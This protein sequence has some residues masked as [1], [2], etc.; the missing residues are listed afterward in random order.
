MTEWL[1]QFE[2]IARL[3]WAPWTL[4][5]AAMNVRIRFAIFA[6]VI[7][8]WLVAALM[9]G[10]LYHSV[11]RPF[12]DPSRWLRDLPVS[13]LCGA[14]IIALFAIL[15][16]LAWADPDMTTVAQRARLRAPLLA[17]FCVIV[18][19]GAWALCSTLFM[20][21]SIVNGGLL[22]EESP[23]GVIV[24][25]SV[26]LLLFAAI[27]VALPLIAWT[28]LANTTDEPRCRECGY[29][30]IGLTARRCP[31]CGREF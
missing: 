15:F 24:T 12:L 18:P 10:G 8:W 29:L 17:P 31:E 22:W 13:G 5:H 16:L 21:G 7:G 3:I 26:W 6:G 9:L 11:N 4:A 27:I 20:R 1:K 25:S 23:L 2:L 28:K 19:L 30:L 14:G